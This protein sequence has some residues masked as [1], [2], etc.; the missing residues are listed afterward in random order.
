MSVSRL[1]G[2]AALRAGRVDPVLGRRQRRDSPRLEVLAAQVG[3]QHRQLVV[4]DRH[5]AI[6]VAVDDR[7][8]AAPEPLARNQPVPQPVGRRGG[9]QVLA[10]QPVDDQRLGL[11]AGHPVEADLV[12][13]GVDRRAVAGVGVTIPIRRRCN[14]SHDRQVER[15]REVPVPLVLR[16]HAHDRAVTV[17][18]QDVVGGVDRQALAVHRVDRMTLQEDPGLGPVGRQPLDLAGPR[19][20][21]PV[22]RELR[23]RRGACGQLGG[24]VGVGRDHEERRAEER[25]RPRRVDRDRLLAT[26]DDEVHVGAGR[27]ADPVALHEEHPLGPATLEQRHV[28][29]QTLGVIGDLEVPL[30]QGLLDDGRAAALA[31]PV[32]DLLVGQHRLVLGTPVDRGGLAVGQAALVEAREQ[33]LGPA[34]VLRVGGVQAGRPVDRDGVAPVGLGLGLDVG[35]GPVGRVGIALDRGVLGRAARRSPS[36]SGA[37]RC[38]PAGT[39]SARR[40]RRSRR[41]RRDPC[42]GRRRGRR[43]CRRCSASPVPRQRGRRV[44]VVGVVRGVGG[45]ER[46]ELG[47]DRAP[48]FLQDSGVVG[49]AHQIANPIGPVI[50]GSIRRIGHQDCG[51]APG[52]CRWAGGSWLRSRL[53]GRYGA[54]EASRRNARRS[55]ISRWARS[56]SDWSVSSSQ[57]SLTARPALTRP[58]QTEGD[59]GGDSTIPARTRRS[60]SSA[61]GPDPAPITTNSSP[62]QRATTSP[63][64]SHRSASRRRRSA[65]RRRSAGRARG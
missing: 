52:R 28:V 50:D 54:A 26:L 31:V 36:R 5:L 61:D 37:A 48:A 14:S 12:V 22:R 30:G 29:E 42:A 62:P 18:G 4:R 39:S 10:R 1:A 11:V 32:D 16:R 59:A 65:P 58:G 27:A 3:Q 23:L 47:P 35:V 6:D 44:G 53:A 51:A 63:A 60:T 25:V 41:P 40:R 19:D 24:Q 21:L 20:L 7:D 17:V 15:L 57:G 9:A 45:T 34:V 49:L 13:R 33:P 55:S 38:S 46:V 2:P 56:S 43:T 64:R 8:R